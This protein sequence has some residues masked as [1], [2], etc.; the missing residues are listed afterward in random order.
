MPDSY[1]FV[2]NQ[3]S[4]FSFGANQKKK[5]PQIAQSS[6]API[7]MSQPD[8]AQPPAQAPAQQPM[9]FMAALAPLIQAASTMFAKPQAAVPPTLTPELIRAMRPDP[10]GD[11][12]RMAGLPSYVAG[13]QSPFNT[14]FFNSIGAPQQQ[15]VQQVGAGVDDFTRRLFQSRF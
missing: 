12:Y 13:S 1:S 7:P 8:A 10:A 4:P 11:A 14:G 9:S 2:A 15:A 3:S 5:K 6:A